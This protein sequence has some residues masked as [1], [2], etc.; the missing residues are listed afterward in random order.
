MTSHLARQLNALGLLAISA[1]LLFAF[2][3][4]FVGGELPCP[5]CI[6]QRAGFVV[7]G[8]GLAL[9][10]LVGVRPAHY[11]LMI[12]GAVGG[13]AVALRQIALHV[14]PG[15]GAYGAPFLGLHFYT[16]A[17]IVFAAIVAGGG[18]LLLFNRQ[19]DSDDYE[20][21]GTLGVLAVLL[22]ALAAAG[23]GV[24]TLAECS[25]GLCPD[26]PTSYQG[27]EALKALLSGS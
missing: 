24:S 25:L 6:L 21:R 13:G 14:V 1:V 9:N 4:Q 7:A 10:I 5:L 3:D 11:G 12:L 15:T 27:V 16:W 2:F 22:F 8:A 19:F 26:D 18:V 23:N 17:F 20:R